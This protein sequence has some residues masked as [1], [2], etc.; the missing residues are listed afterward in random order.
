METSIS[1]IIHNPEMEQK[2][3]HAVVQDLPMPEGLPMA[4]QVLF[5]G[6]R[7]I[8]KSYTRGHISSTDASQERIG[9]EKACRYFAFRD[10][11]AFD[12]EGKIRATEAARHAYRKER[13]LENADRLLAAIEG[14]V[15]TKRSE[16]VVW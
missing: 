8:Y 2:V 7:L 16:S 3:L 14:N 12:W 15:K 4:G 13:T 6:L 10:D 1:T 9:L 11:L 5:A